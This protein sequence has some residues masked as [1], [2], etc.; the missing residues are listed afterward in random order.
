MPKKLL[1]LIIL[2]S[3]YL[4]VCFYIYTNSTPINTYKVSTNPLKEVIPHIKTEQPIG[5]ITIPKINL[6]KNLYT[7]TSQLNNIEQN[8]T[9][10]PESGDPALKNTTLFIAA[11]SGTGP[12]AYF[13]NLDKLTINDKII[14]SYNANNYTYIIK[15]IWEIP[16]TGSISVP[17]QDKNQL[18]LTTCSPTKSNYQL[19][20]NCIRQ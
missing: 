13:N 14:I 17:K 15:S 4:I 20:V 1:S 16:K 18:V 8:V 12:L 2:L 10:L 7:P 9:I 3:I 19:I 5:S 11:H 6:N